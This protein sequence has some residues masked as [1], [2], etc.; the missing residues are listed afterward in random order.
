MSLSALA[1]LA[2]YCM[3]AV[4]TFL[5]PVVGM[6]GYL[7]EYYRRPELQWWRH[8]LPSWRWNL[9]ISVIWGL[10]FLLRRSSLREMR[11][12]KNL[13]L[14][15]LLA[16]TVLMVLVTATFAVDPVLSQH[17]TIQWIKLAV[18]VPLLMI[19][20]VRKRGEFHLFVAANMLGVLRWGYDAWIDPDR[21]QGRLLNVGS[22]D[23]LN[24]NAASIHLLTV[25]P[26]I[27]VYLLT[28]K[29]KRLR[30][31]ALVTL[32]FVI[33]TL[34][35][36]NSRG[37]MVGLGVA[38]VAGVFLIRSQ[39]RVR[40]ATAALAGALGF[41]LLADDTFIK[42]QQTTAEYKTD[43]AAQ[44]RFESWK[45]G[46]AL[47]SDRPFGSGGRGFHV[48]SPRYIP[49]IVE[50]HDGDGRA[51]HNTYVMV[52]SEWGVLGLAIWI[53]FH[54]STF[55]MLRRV[56]ARAHGTDFY[57]WRA[58]GL[59]VSLIAVLFASMFADRLYGEAPYWL[60]A[61]VYALYRMQHT[62]QAEK[63]EQTTDPRNLAATGAQRPE[64]AGGY[65][66]A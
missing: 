43:G 14:P 58:F 49:A 5:N 41:F 52:A 55:V 21:E 44:E 2:M 23:S 37:A 3:A 29:D 16:M 1:W 4:L 31:L 8:D 38:G 7:L 42:R 59:Q 66:A 56:K 11:P 53:G 22:G 50:S 32:P 62:E 30:A 45:G 12:L 9:V 39:Y 27:V 20:S 63:L 46:I 13:S 19:G 6:L 47:V 40:F 34:I 60:A 18:I 36:C 48:L 26:M 64:P 51:P 15:W 57:Y 28:E 25:L 65:S 61:M 17:W 24:D 35:L 10:S 33:N 54:T